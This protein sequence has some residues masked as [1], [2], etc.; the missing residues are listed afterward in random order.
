MRQTH[1]TV[2]FHT[3]GCKVNQ[4]ESDRLADSFKA[5]GHKVVPFSDK[6]DVYVVNTCAVTNLADRKSRQMLRRAM[7]KNMDALVVATGCSAEQLKSL[8]IKQF[9]VVPNKDK[10]A[11]LKLVEESI[12]GHT[13]SYEELKDIPYFSA[14]GKT[15]AFLKIQDGCNR[16][17]TFCIIPSRRGESKSRPINEL[18]LEV[19]KLEESGV[20]E[21]VLT[22]VCIGDYGKDLPNQPALADLIV[23]LSNYISKARI[24]LSSIDPGDF[25][26]VLLA[27]FYKLNNLCPHVHL[28]L[29]HVSSR[30]LKRMNRFYTKEQLLSIIDKMSEKLPNL[31]VTADVMVGFP[32]E[33]ESDFLELLEFVGHKAFCKLHIFTYSE[34][35][36][37]AALKLKERVPQVEK[38]ARANALL[39]K[40]KEIAKIYRNR[41]IGKESLV[42]I[43]EI[44]EENYNTGENKGDQLLFMEGYSENYLR[45]RMPKY[46]TKVGNFETVYI[47]RGDDKYVY[48]IPIQ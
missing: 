27:L 44:S 33:T 30:V 48:G 3:L 11:A 9:L 26:D 24:R 21:I 4:Y 42:L 20:K 19:K 40:G 1:L 32:G 6:A 43:E 46:C 41:F 2:A 25:D 7:G 13:V 14:S 8:G 10:D 35:P 36:E 37:T 5:A 31:A 12:Y 47:E 34:R 38:D 18:I 15:R 28:S 45:V 23:S 16:L 22:G 29:Q 17:C 39:A